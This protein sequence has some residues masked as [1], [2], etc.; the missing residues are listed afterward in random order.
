MR[1]IFSGLGGRVLAGGQRR[2]PLP[3]TSL[4]RCVDF[5]VVAATDDDARSDGSDE[6]DLRTL[7]EIAGGSQEA[8]ARLYDRY[9]GPLLA[10]GQR[11]LRSRRDAEDVLHDVFVEVWQLAGDY[12]RRRG[13]VRAWLFLR[14]RSRSIDRLRLSSAKDVELDAQLLST[15]PAQAAEDPALAPDRQRV[16]LV[17]QTLPREQREALELAWFGGLSGSQIAERLGAPLG[18]IKTRLALGMSKLRAAFGTQ[19][20]T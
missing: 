18:T 8:L 15:M 10:A 9:A 4:G 3:L 1:A 13:S 6:S 14:M 5:A 16:H 2:L 11:T 17:L 12:D 20:A 7:V 19:E